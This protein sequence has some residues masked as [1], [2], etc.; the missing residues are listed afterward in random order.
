MTDRLT[1]ENATRAPKL[2]IAAASSRLM[3]SATN[4][5]A[6]TTRMARTG[7]RKRTLSCPKTRRG[8]TPSRPM[9][10]RIRDTLACEAMAEAKHPAM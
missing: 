6:P 10:Y 1:K 4:E 8:R 5:T 2:I 3:N 7:V 9:A